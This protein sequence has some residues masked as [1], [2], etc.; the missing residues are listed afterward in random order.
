MHGLLYE[1]VETIEDHVDVTRVRALVEDGI[2]IGAT[3]NFD[4]ATRERS[5]ILL[6]FPRAHRVALHQAVRLVALEPGLDEGE[7]QPLGE[8][9]SVA[10]LE[11]PPHPLGT[12]DHT[13]DEPREPV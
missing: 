6:L 11:V 13:V 1:V 2:E 3:G 4:I 7:Q 9:E 8:V 5:K 12:H 10:R